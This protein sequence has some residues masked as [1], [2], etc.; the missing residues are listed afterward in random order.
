VIGAENA[1]E[2]N[3]LEEI[4]VVREIG[5]AEGAEKRAK[6]GTL[7]VGDGGFGS[8]K[9]PKGDTKKRS[10]A[11]VCFCITEKPARGGNDA[12]DFRKQA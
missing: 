7:R 11:T 8:Q 6:G 1:A 4:A 3:Q 2:P 12:I 5:L 9:R 10:Q